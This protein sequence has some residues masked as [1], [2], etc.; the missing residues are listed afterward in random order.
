MT[1]VVHSGGCL[2]GAVRYQAAGEPERV[3]NCHCI[4]CRK[5]SGAA[6]LTFATFRADRVAIEGEPAFFRSSESAERGFC[7]ACGSTLFWR[8][9]GSD[10]IDVS[11]GTLDGPAALP[12][13][14][15]LFTK[16]RIAWFETVD[17]LPRH[18]AGRPETA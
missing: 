18:P 15:H 6:M 17:D 4:Q 8:R 16:D 12:P 10:L 3:N 1:A 11:A 2:C 7:P 14:E 13:E 9:V 5:S